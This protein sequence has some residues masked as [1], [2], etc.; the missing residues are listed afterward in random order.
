MVNGIKV[1]DRL[2]GDS[3]YTAQKLRMK[4]TLKDTQ[5]IHGKI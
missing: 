3:N 5:K 2:E 1:E 4:V